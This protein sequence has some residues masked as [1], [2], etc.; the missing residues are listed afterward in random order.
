M[1]EIFTDTMT[2]SWPLNCKLFVISSWYGS[3]KSPPNLFDFVITVTEKP[4]IIVA[5]HYGWK[6][7]LSK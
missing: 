5:K 7:L 6:Q 3:G 1:Y 2:W 4:S